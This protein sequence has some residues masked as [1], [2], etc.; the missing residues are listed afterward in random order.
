MHGIILKNIGYQ[1]QVLERSAPE[2]LES[3]AAGIRVGPEVYDFIQQHV[4][5]SSEYFVTAENLEIM[6]SEN[7][8]V[9]KLPPQQPLRLTT[10]KIV[11]DLLKNALLKSV[12][13]E[14]VAT[15]KTRRVVQDVAQVGEKITVTVLDLED[16]TTTAIESDLVIAADGAHST[17]RKKLCPEVVPRYAGY[18]TWRG[19]VPESAVPSKTRDALRDRCAILRVEGGYQIS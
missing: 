6:D 1:V 4:R 17:I 5:P 12:D 9:Q 13:M 19:R 2:A 18:V 15:Y 11:Y 16:G 7:N 3:Q 14:H 8:Y 10:W